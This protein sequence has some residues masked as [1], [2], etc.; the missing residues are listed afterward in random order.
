[1][2]KKVL[3]N[4]RGYFYICGLRVVSFNYFIFAVWSS[5]SVGTIFLRLRAHVVFNVVSILGYYCEINSW[6]PAS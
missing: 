5:L 2:K 4:F 6:G 3:K 1:M